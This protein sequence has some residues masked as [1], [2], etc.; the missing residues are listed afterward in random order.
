MTYRKMMDEA[1]RIATWL[2]TATP[3]QVLQKSRD[4]TKMVSVFY[5][6]AYEKWILRKFNI[7]RM[8]D[9]VWGGSG[10]PTDDELYAHFGHVVRV[11]RGRV[12]A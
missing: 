3:D 5:A 12:I 8:G 11:V 7:A 4:D 10:E 9:E 2:E 1:Q 6:P